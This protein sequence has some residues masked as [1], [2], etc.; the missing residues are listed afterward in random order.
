MRYWDGNAWTGHTNA[1][2]APPAVPIQPAQPARGLAKAVTILL[3]IQIAILAGLT[4]A[5]VNYRSEAQ[6]FFDEGSVFS[7]QEV[8][9]AE[10]LYDAVNGI[11]VLSGIAIAVLMI[12]WSFKTSKWAQA[13]GASMR[14]GPGWAIGAW[15]IPI[16]NTVLVFLVLNDL[17]RYAEP[18]LPRP[19]GDHHRGRSG[20][21]LLWGWL[22]GLITGA[23][24]L[25]VGTSLVGSEDSTQDEIMNGLTMRI[26]GAG[27]GAVAV[28]FLLL[29]VRATQA[30]VE[31]SATTYAPVVPVTPISW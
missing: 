17:Y 1:G 13:Q 28:L 23:V 22:A 21:N 26:I 2:V 15:F 20:T 5:A 3:G 4:L 8:I 18:G 10:D 27:A 9:D 24:L 19:I 11:T 30:R 31:A 25:N 29:Y 14:F 6:Q 12:I 16:A 7:V